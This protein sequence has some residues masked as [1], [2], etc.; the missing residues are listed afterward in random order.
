M[1]SAGMQVVSHILTQAMSSTESDELRMN[2]AITLSDV[3]AGYGHNVV[4]SGLS[5]EIPTGR[6]AGIVGPTGCGK[7]TLLKTI[8]GAQP[9]FSGDVRLNGLPVASVPLGTIGYVPQLGSVD[10]N[11]PVTVEEVIMMGFMPVSASGRG[12]AGKNASVR[13]N[14]LTGSAFTIVCAS[15]S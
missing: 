14:W 7:T 2:A 10:W 1:R 5:L 11:F 9:I 3:T 4:F 6:F 12:Q 8:L 13:T 15:P